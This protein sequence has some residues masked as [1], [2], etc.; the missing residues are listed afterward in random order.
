MNILQSL[1]KV[2]ILIAISFVQYV[3]VAHVLMYSCLLFRD[4]AFT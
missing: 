2:S 1:L 4:S 3:H